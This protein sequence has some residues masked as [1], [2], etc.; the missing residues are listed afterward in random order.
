MIMYFVT[1]FNPKDADLFHRAGSEDILVSYWVLQSGRDPEG[2]IKAFYDQL[3][4]L[5]EPK[6][7]YTETG[8]VIKSKRGNSDEIEDD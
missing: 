6:L 3:H 8:E 7:Q 2:K 4:G 1:D 5:K